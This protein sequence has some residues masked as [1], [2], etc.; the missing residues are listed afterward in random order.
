MKKV[1]SLILSFFI[2]LSL[3]L[4]LAF[5]PVAVAGEPFSSGS[6]TADAPYVIS[7]AEQLSAIRN[8]FGAC[9]QLGADIDLSSYNTASGW[10]PIGSKSVQ[11]KGMLDGKGYKIK[12][13]FI[14]NPENDFVGL[15]ARSTGEIKNLKLENVNVSGGKI[16]GGLVGDNYK[17]TIENCH[18]NGTVS[19]DYNVGG[20]VGTNSTGAIE[21]CSSIGNVSGSNLGYGGGLVGYNYQGSI[22]SCFSTGRVSAAYNVGGLVGGNSSGDIK[23]CYSTSA[24]QG[25]KCIGGLVGLDEDG[26]IEN[27]YSIGTVTGIKNVGGLVARSTGSIISSYYDLESSG[28]TDNDGRGTPKTTAEMMQQATFNN[29]DFNIW[30]IVEGES[31]PYLRVLEP[32]VDVLIDYVNNLDIKGES[33]ISQLENVNRLLEEKNTAATVNKLNA[34]INHVNAQTGKKLSKTEAYNMISIARIIIANN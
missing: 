31:Y 26:S 15:F 5:D 11:F 3:V 6:G 20:L 14:K 18:I 17:G 25:S 27:C 12:N 32:S 34:F 28:Q 21:N 7:T 1:N 24:V 29:W 23:N 4:V 22:E 9:Y 10:Q 13:L 16:I 33:F 2:S 8:D 30:S 19:G